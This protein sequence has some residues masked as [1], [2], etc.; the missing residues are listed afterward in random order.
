MEI[1]A[2][3]WYRAIGIR[4]SCRQY[5]RKPLEGTVLAHLESLT[6][7]LN[8]WMEG[9]R[10]VLVTGDPEPV[11]KGIIGSYGK[12]QNAPAY[13]AFIGDLSHPQVQEKTGYLGECFLL[14]ATALGLATCWVGGF[15]RPEVV[16]RQIP[17]KDKER[18]LA[19]SPVGYWPEDRNLSEL[20]ASG[21]LT[22]KRKE[23][24]ALVQGLPQEKWPWWAETALEAARLAPSAVNRQPWIFEVGEQDIKVLA[25]RPLVSFGISTRL[26]CGI[27]MLHLEVGARQAGARGRWEYLQPPAVAVYRAEEC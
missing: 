14:E 27:A 1:P 4:R 3:R 18:V 22:H 12:I 26:D 23:L 2:E 15:F 17:V 10:A 7:Q 6:R 9:A 13:V 20:M 25:H 19:V 16:K 24:A 8:D 11:F 21:A 5:A